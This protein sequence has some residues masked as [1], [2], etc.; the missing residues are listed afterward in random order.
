MNNE[1][2]ELPSNLSPP[3][4]YLSWE[5]LMVKLFSNQNVKGLEQVRAIDFNILLKNHIKKYTVFIEGQYLYHALRLAGHKVVLRNIVSAPQISNPI[6]YYTV[7]AKESHDA[8]K[9]FK[10]LIKNTPEVSGLFRCVPTLKPYDSKNKEQVRDNRLEVSSIII[11]KLITDML[12]LIINVD[13]SNIETNA[14]VL[15][16]N[17]MALMP[18]IQLLINNDIAVYLGVSKHLK[19]SPRLLKLASAIID[20]EDYLQGISALKK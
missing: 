11:P 7:W 13:E 3:N 5:D 6:Y 19:T 2:K 17:N 15:L 18:A 10:D 16:S 8:A 14:I 20:I 9:A 12:S 1:D 4:A